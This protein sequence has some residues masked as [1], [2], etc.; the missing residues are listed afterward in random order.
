MSRAPRGGSADAC[1]P[2]RRPTHRHRRSLLHLA[3][4]GGG[5]GDP[6]P[7]RRASRVQ[8]LARGGAKPE[9]T[10][11]PDFDEVV[12]DIARQSQWRKIDLTPKCRVFG[13]LDDLEGV[14]LLRLVR[15]QGRHRDVAAEDGERPALAH[16]AE[17]VAELGF[18][19]GDGHGVHGHSMTITGQD[20]N[21]RC[22]LYTSPSPRDG[23]LSR[24]PSS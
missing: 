20:D 10:I 4:A 1:R 6:S 24:M 23:L 5:S 16:L 13:G 2:E 9:I 11:L 15:T 14:D 22:L 12:D 18:E 19:F 21:D 3:S 8:R 17:V 7:A